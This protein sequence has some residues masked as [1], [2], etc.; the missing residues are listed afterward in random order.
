M[1]IAI[2][3]IFFLFTLFGSFV[4]AVASEQPLDVSLV[5]L[6]AN[7]EDYHGKVIRVIGYVRLE[8]EGDAIYLHQDD[9]MLGIYKNGLWIDVTYDIRK[10]EEEFDR[11]YVLVEGTFN[12]ERT[13]HFGLFSGTIEKIKRFQKWRDTK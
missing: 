13:G 1:S 4:P 6:I 12:S 11:K 2:R 3:Y 8:F 7:P 5:Q 9:G 10:K